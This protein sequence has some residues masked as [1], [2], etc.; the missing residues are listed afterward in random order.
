MAQ[1][2]KLEDYISR[3]EWD[4]YRYPTQYIRLKNDNWRKIHE[5]WSRRDD[6]KEGIPEKS[7]S[8]SFASRWKSLFGI[9]STP[10]EEQQEE[11]TIGR[12]QPETEKDLRKSFLDQ[13]YSFQLKWASSTVNRISF[14]DR[15]YYMDESL[16][17]FLQRFPDTYLLMYY[18]IFHIR[19]APVDGEIIL[20]SPV[21]IEVIKL[22]EEP[23]GHLLIDDNDRTW[24]LETGDGSHKILN[25]FI[26]LK[27]TENIVKSVLQVKQIDF[28]VRKTVLS[29]TNNI[30]VSSRYNNGEVVGRHEYPKWFEARRNLESPLKNSQLKAAEALLKY[31][32]T[33]S[34]K[35]QE[36]QEDEDVFSEGNG[37]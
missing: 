18:P 37:K 35:R 9:K 4:I 7:Q 23:L 32:L 5:D 12:S 17:Y 15:K 11:R 16:K 22:V 21:S 34:V 2:I 33:H 1:L 28:P 10:A 6:L 27:R 20:I 13:L 8:S 24:K 30:I 14:M 36:W 31:C 26:A 29:R 3:Y 25:P 19:N